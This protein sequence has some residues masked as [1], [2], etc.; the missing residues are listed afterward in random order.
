MRAQ[1]DNQDNANVQHIR[2]LARIRTPRCAG[3]I[4]QLAAE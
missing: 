4:K 2:H 3:Y 1:S